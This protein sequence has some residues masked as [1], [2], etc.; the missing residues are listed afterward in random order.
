MA[1]PTHWSRTTWP[2]G[3]CDI[4]N[5]DSQESDEARARYA[6]EIQMRK[7]KVIEHISLDSLIRYSADD[8]DFTYS[9]WTART[10]TAAG[11]HAVMTAH[12]ESFDL[13]F[14]RRTYEIWSGFWPKPPSSPIAD[15][16]ADV[17]GARTRPCGRSC[18]DRLQSCWARGSAS[19][20]RDLHHAHSS[21][22]YE[23]NAVRFHLQYL[24]GR[25]GL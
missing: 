5:A 22:Q 18:A 14:G 11:R 3:N 19:L 12:G 24:Q 23:S 15:R 10:R 21:W 20:R 6:Q 4:K 2:S 16:H 1:T 13:L 17:D 7:L 25:R 8:G 9:D